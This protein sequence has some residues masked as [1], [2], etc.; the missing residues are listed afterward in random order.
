MAD[1]TVVVTNRAFIENDVTPNNSAD[2]HDY[3]NTLANESTPDD[4]HSYIVFD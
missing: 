4:T 2:E 1:D 3:Q